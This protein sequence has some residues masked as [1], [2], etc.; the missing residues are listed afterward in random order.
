M[1][2]RFRRVALAVTAVVAVAIAGGVTYA[3]A[4][5]GSG[6]VINGCYKSQNGQLRLIDPSTDSCHPSETPISWSQTGP[7]GQKGDKGD[8]GPPGPQGPPGPTDLSKFSRAASA[9]T[10]AILN[11]GGDFG[12]VT[13]LS[14]NLTS[15]SS[16][17]FVVV[18]ANMSAWTTTPA[19]CP[20]QIELQVRDATAGV[21]AA[22]DSF[23]QVGNVADE[24]GLAMDNAAASGV[25]PIG[26]NQTHQYDFQAVVD[27]GS[28]VTV[29]ARISMTAVYVPFNGAGSATALAALMPQ[30]ARAN[31]AAAARSSTQARTQPKHAA[32]SGTRGRKGR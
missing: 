5:I 10:D 3:V 14:T 12:Y 8:P 29:I 18:H 30:A 11:N 17:G 22:S 32:R 27:D 24:D 9:A 21:N 16:P 15:G 20:C 6:A 23:A 28:A 1:R 25:F 7:A 19:A 26:A 2:R 13:E 4:D 31:P